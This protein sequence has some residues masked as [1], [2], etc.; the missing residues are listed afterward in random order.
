MGRNSQAEE[1]RSRKVL[2]LQSGKGLSV[3]S[4]SN[5]REEETP[6]TGTLWVRLSLWSELTWVWMLMSLPSPA[7]F[8]V[9]SVL[10]V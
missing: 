9:L 3:H 7:G 5:G 10:I 2:R 8:C 6:Q 1:T 4:P